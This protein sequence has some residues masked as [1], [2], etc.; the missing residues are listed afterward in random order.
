MMRPMSSH[1]RLRPRYHRLV[2]FAAAVTVTGVSVLGSVA[3]SGEVEDVQAAPHSGTAGA[4]SF[5]A[6]EPARPHRRGEAAEST[7]PPADG[8]ELAPPVPPDSGQGRRV[9][10]DL[11]EQ[12]VWLVA[13]DG[14]ARRT[15]L[16]SGSR[17]DNLQ[18]GSYEVYSRSARAWGIDGSRLRFMVR[19][20][21]GRNAAIGFH[22]IPVLDGERVQTRSQLGTA[23]SH[24]C[25]RQALG[26]AKALWDFAPVGTKVVVT[27]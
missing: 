6:A 23:L 25:V 5:M 9:V 20:A 19:F 18:P 16:V 3:G 4:L 17:F 10:F 8:S 22:S 14:R 11:S 1:K 13:A 24:G 12:R 26:D 2:A 15:H 21:H 7:V 27:D